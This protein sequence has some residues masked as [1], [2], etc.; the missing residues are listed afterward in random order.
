M[1]AP[2]LPAVTKPATFFSRT[3]FRPTRIELSF[4][5]RTA[6]RSLLVHADTFRGMVDDDRQIFVFEILIQQVAQLRLRTD[7]MHAHRQSPAS[8]NGAANLRL[9]SFVRAKSVQRN[10]HQRE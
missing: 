7:Q 8:L 10:I 6:M 4:L 9:R 2:V 1:A 5:V 3:S